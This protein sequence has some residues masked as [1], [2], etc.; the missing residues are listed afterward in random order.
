MWW[1][2]RLPKGFCTFFT[3]PRRNHLDY[4]FKSA[5]VTFS[6]L[7]NKRTKYRNVVR[8]LF[9]VAA[10]FAIIFIIREFMVQWPMV[11]QWR[12]SSYDL[13]ILALA[14]LVYGISLFFLA[15]AWHRLLHVFHPN[16]V[17]RKISYGIYSKTQ[18][19]KYLPGNILHLAGRNIL[20]ASD[21]IGHRSLLKITFLETLLMASAALIIASCGIAP[22]LANIYGQSAFIINGVFICAV[23]ILIYPVFWAIPGHFIE[24]V[25]QVGLSLGFM[26]IFFCLYG[27]IFLIISCL[28]GLQIS[29]VSFSSA[30][31]SWVV[32]FVTP[33]APGG[34]GIREFSLFFL[35]RDISVEAQ[36]LIA[37]AFFRIVTLLGDIVCLGVGR[38]FLR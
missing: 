25:K 20:V 16:C 30:P 29:M 11:S 15:E 22:H 2:D 33:G 36:L 7:I 3:L 24:R 8:S 4:L 19:A 23:I 21:T 27:G 34:M 10:L 6:D 32:G 13:L 5:I 26:L 31:L 35:L 12:F 17:N 9:T 37:M 28:I 18:V 38:I 14:A 1:V